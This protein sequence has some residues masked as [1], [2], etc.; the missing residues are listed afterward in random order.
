MKL[1]AALAATLLFVVVLAIVYLV[2]VRWFT[3]D[4]ILYAAVADALIAVAITL[5]AALAARALAPRL[6]PLGGFEIGLL[7]LIW[8]LGGWAFAITGPTVLDRSLSIYILEKLH[9]RGGGIREDAIARVFVEEYLPEFRLVDVRLTEQLRSGT[10][11]IRDGCVRLTP[12]GERVVAV[13][14]VL[15][16]NFLAR[17]R[18]LAGVYTDAL[19]DPFARSRAGVMG[20]ECR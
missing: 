7:A 8:L 16:R 1:L 4:V 13:T 19:V 14:D 2:H 15:R 12:R 6:L 9:Q 18:L 17:N 5:V 10:I 20:Y 3:V 11:E